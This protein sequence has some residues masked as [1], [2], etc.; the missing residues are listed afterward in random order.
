MAR[1]I[2][3]SNRKTWLLMFLCL[4]MGAAAFGIFIVLRPKPGYDLN[5]RLLPVREWEIRHYTG[6]PR[7]AFDLNSGYRELRDTD[8]R[9]YGPLQI[10]R[11]K[12]LRSGRLTTPGHIQWEIGGPPP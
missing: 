9:R 8:V 3:R 11:S 6:S 12:V 5:I 4:W 7:W 1:F 2:H 10:V